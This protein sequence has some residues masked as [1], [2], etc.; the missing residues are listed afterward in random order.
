VQRAR[1]TSQ[2]I[3]PRGSWPRRPRSHKLKIQSEQKA[4][5]P[6]VSVQPWSSRLGDERGAFEVQKYSKR[7]FLITPHGTR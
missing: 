1:G 4:A 7:R 3:T 6:G 2:V 5:S